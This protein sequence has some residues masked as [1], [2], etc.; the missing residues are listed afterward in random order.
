MGTPDFAVEILKTLVVNE[1]NIVAV[2]TTPDKPAGRG[3]KIMESAVKKYAVSQNIPVLQPEKLKSSEF[4]E[5]LKSFQPELQIV[6][7]FRMLPKIVWNLP[8]KGTFNLHASLLPQYR[9]AA[10]IN[11][12]VINGE[13]K[14]GVTTFLLDEQI[15]TGKIMF[16]EEVE[17]N[18][19]DN[20][21]TLHDKLMYTGAGLVLKTVDLI[22]KGEVN[23]INQDEY[24]NQELKHAPKIFKNDCKINWDNDIE[25]V[26]NFIRGLSPYPAAWTEASSGETGKTVSMKL[27]DVEKIILAHTDPIGCINS[28]GKDSLNIAVKNGYIKV[29]TLQLAGKK[30]MKTEDFLK[31]FQKAN[32]YKCI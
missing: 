29:N 22:E 21:G 2:V 12:A 11:W 6:V 31:G 4:I 23:A 28:D 10:P 9:G 30:R 14:T 13:K 18:D 20:A 7:A 25:S 16:R 5:E 32:T 17:I 15:D 19:T 3:Q 8:P 27:Y 1:Y 26:Y 24:I